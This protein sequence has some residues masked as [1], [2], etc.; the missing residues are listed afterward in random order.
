MELVNVLSQIP[1]PVIAVALLILAIITIVLAYQ[2]AKM[3]GLDGIRQDVYQL[4]LKAEH[5][6]NESGQ[7]KQKLKYVVSQARGLLPKWLQVFVTEEAMMKVIDKWFEGVKDL[8]D[9][10]RV[11]G[12]Q[13]SLLEKGGSAMWDIILFVYLLGILLS[14]PVYIW[15]IGTLCRMEDE[16]EE[17]YCQDNGLYYEPRKP[18][19]PLVMV[20]MVLA[21]I[22]WP[23]VIL[24][25][26]FLPLTFILMDK[27]GQLHPEED[28]K[29]DPE[30]DTY[31]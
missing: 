6:Y 12:S 2:Y 25:A 8:L 9:D 15:A 1:L 10:G 4:I 17:L 26:I 22:F 18:N 27:M 21:G 3:Q 28:E 5:I 11:N 24:F 29:L 16:D 13:K 20:L 7:G 14:Q 19:Y 30:E 31:L 23:L